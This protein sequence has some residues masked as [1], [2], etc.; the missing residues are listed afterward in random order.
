MTKSNLKTHLKWL[1]DQGR[2]L[3]PVLTPSAWESHVNPIDSHSTSGA[4]LNLIASQT[5]DLSTKDSQPAPA[6]T[7]DI[8]LDDVIEL[9]SDEENMARL[10]L[11]P[12][13]SASKPRMLSTK[14]PPSSVR[15]SSKSS[16]AK[17]ESTETPRSIPLKEPPSSL[18]SF[19]DRK[20]QISTPVQPKRQL[21][22]PSSIHSFQDIDT[23][24]LTD[25]L[26]LN[27]LSSDIREE[28]GEPRRFWTED[29]ASRK[30]PT[31]KRG[32]KRKSDEYA[33]DLVSPRASS[34][35]ARSPRVSSSTLQSDHFM[36]TH[37]SRRT[38]R[39]EP[40]PSR[41]K[42][43]ESLSLKRADRA[44]AIPNSD[45]E[46]VESLFESF[47]EAKQPS[48]RTSSK[49]LYPVL[50]SD[51]HSNTP[52][53]IHSPKRREPISPDSIDI[54]E[55]TRPTPL[56]KSN[57]NS[58]SPH[59]L[60][61]L[62]SSN[63]A[64]SQSASR[65]PN[66]ERF[67]QIPATSLSRLLTCL[68]ETVRKNS[69][70][71]YEAMLNG[72][73]SPEVHALISENAIYH[74]QQRA[75]EALITKKSAYLQREAESKSLRD[76]IMHVLNQG[77]SNVQPKVEQQKEIRTQMKDME[78]DMRDL[79]R[80]ADLFAA[81]EIYSLDTRASELEPLHSLRTVPRHIEELRDRS[82]DKS[83]AASRTSFKPTYN[84]KE[85]RP[86]TS[87]FATNSYISRSKSPN[88]NRFNYNDPTVS[89]G[90]TTFTRTMGSPLPPVE[91]FDDF[92]MDGFD[93]DILR[94]AGN[95]AGGQSFST[96]RPEPHD[97][98]VFA[99]TSGNACRLP[100]TQKSQT[101]GTLW[102]QHPW[103]KDVKIALKERFHLRGFRSNQLEAIDSTLSGKDT[104]VL[105]P[106]G[107]GKSLCYQL[108]SV[109][110]SGST[111]GV[112]IVVSPLLS[113]M[114][115]QVAHLRQNKI[116]AYLVNGDTPLAERQ[117]IMS[118]LSSRSP[119]THIEVLY[120]TP[121]MIGKSQALTDRME[122]LCC[123]QKLAR[124]VIDEAH[125]VSQWGHDF[126]PDYKE[127]GAFRARIP[128]I[129][130]MALT[131][132][133]TEN[134]KVDVIHNLKM[135]GC[136]VFTQSFNRPNLTYE[137]REKGKNAEL[138]VNIAEIIKTSYRNKCG[139][140]Y[141]LSRTTCEKV[142]EVLRKNHRIKAEHYHAGLDAETRANTQQRWQAGEVH[143]I[144]ATI[145][146]GMGI[147]KPDVRFVIHHSIPKSLEGYYQETGRAGRD[148]RRSGC[149][150]FYALRDVTTMQG[151]I[152][153]NEDASDEQIGR[154]LRMLGQVQK[155]CE[156]GSD[157]RR[158]QILAY[159][160]EAFKRQDCNASCDNCK[161]EDTVEVRDFS[162]HASAVVKIVRYFQEREENVTPGYC[163]NIFRGTSKSFR[164]PQHREAPCLGDGADINLGDAE[165][166]FRKLLGER[167][168]KEENV[169]NKRSFPIQYLKLGPRASEFESGRRRL[170]LDVRVSSDGNETGRNHLP[171]STNVSSPVQS[172]NRRRLDRYRYDHSAADDSD[173]DMDSDGFERI[174][175]A[176][177][178]DRKGNNL[179]GPPIT[180]DDRFDQLDHLH[181]AVAEDFMVY[182]KNYCQ[183]VV[184]LKGLRSQPFSDT[185]LRE[186]VMVFPKD[187]QEMLQIPNIDPDKV[188]RYGDKILKLIRDTQQ[189]LADLKQEG[190]EADGIVP[191]PN[192]HNVVNVS[193]DD[194]FSDAADI[195]VDHD[196]TLPPDDRVVTSQYFSRSQQPFDDDSADEY[197]PSPKAGNSRSQKRKT[198]SKRPPRRKSGDAKPRAKA[199][200]KPRANGSRS[201]GRSYARKETKGK[202]KP[203]TSQIAMMPI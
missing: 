88:A 192:H 119:E 37:A 49:S 54:P 139:I 84:A 82:F 27:A 99:E 86:S 30:D 109:I 182:A 89:D 190:A 188:N 77:A 198:A 180:Q 7:V 90:E 165:R 105:M 68:Q 100:A 64:S 19:R 129:P 126:R 32:K 16:S 134:V 9:D 135:H 159:F 174:R 123:N 148:G 66:V 1:L 156:N 201:Q 189:R 147:D 158:V 163:V 144:V 197:R 93:E 161:S 124:V 185:I 117:W 14:E 150:L 199:A 5:E 56:L 12:P 22:I 45:D 138:L 6:S 50:P 57:T 58:Q 149:Y 136:D 183:E 120:I 73:S 173:S 23:I 98:L 31:D 69:D 166:L 193:S 67:L 75:I 92:D 63:A 41:H 20:G 29:A 97:R 60:P 128:G 203:P 79:L 171:Q 102:G 96:D 114:Q 122:G 125:C 115:D 53:L 3:Y 87:K 65:D 51:K 35:K 17:R 132:T 106:T 2:S 110:S 169:V 164:S 141:C 74:G 154:Q 186:M 179:P 47:I 52:K 108:P 113:L 70:L 48:P 39:D 10:M 121:E 153:K 71:G 34:R 21:K 55:I 181:R 155:Y 178:K 72:E 167:A 26:D 107:G 157:C 83:P 118:M 59:A 25:D 143:V 36:S 194:E 81:L 195:F 172:A 146:F 162:Q 170:R 44:P 168:L 111:K 78:A 127:I 80:D 15:K 4:T 95:F 11:G 175:V 103:T 140:V 176:G 13:S 42:K 112:T 142:A 160:S 196:S 61:S 24:D 46:D 133:A 184:M 191:D 40:S 62:S 101:H 38:S 137:V 177:R 116:K 18:S 104:F 94:T 152:E 151:M 202:S 8:P 200:R 145:A 91:D 130:F 33:S 85:S 28:F 131:A 187:K 76:D 43:Q